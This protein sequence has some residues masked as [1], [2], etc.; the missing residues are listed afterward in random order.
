MA[1]VLVV[2]DET[3]VRGVLKMMLQRAGH[4]VVV[5]GNATEALRCAKGKPPDLV[6]LDVEMPQMNGFDLCALIKTTPELNRTPVLM[7]TGRP[8]ADVAARARAVG[9]VELLE[10]PFQRDALLK[11]VASLLPPPE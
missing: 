4:D 2:D 1:H 5:A 6:L 9:A 7:M 8:L 10:K 11:K 3:A